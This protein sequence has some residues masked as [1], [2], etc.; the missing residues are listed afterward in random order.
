MIEHLDH[1]VHGENGESL[2]VLSVPPLRDL[3]VKLLAFPHRS[4]ADLRALHTEFTESV[5]ISMIEHLD[6]RGHGENGESLS[7]LSVP[8]LRGLCAK[9]FAFPPL[10]KEFMNNPG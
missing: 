8:P 4:R 3:C 10:S 2:S 7:V 1:R 9:L 6:H 5:P